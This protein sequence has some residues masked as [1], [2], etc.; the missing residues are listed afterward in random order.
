[1]KDEEQS[2]DLT[3]FRTANICN[4]VGPALPLE[5]FSIAYYADEKAARIHDVMKWGLPTIGPENR[6]SLLVR[7]ASK[8]TRTFR[9]ILWA[10]TRRY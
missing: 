8:E 1:M 3:D 10:A 4:I 2:F 6:V 7:N 9:G 5:T